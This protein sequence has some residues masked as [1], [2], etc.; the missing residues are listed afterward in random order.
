[1]AE[2]FPDQFWVSFYSAALHVRSKDFEANPDCSK[3]VVFAVEKPRKLAAHYDLFQTSNAGL[4]CVLSQIPNPE[5]TML[6]RAQYYLQLLKTLR[7][8]AHVVEKHSSEF[9][10]W[11]LELFHGINGDQASNFDHKLVCST[12]PVIIEFLEILS[13]LK[14]PAKLYRANDIFDLTLHLLTN[15]K[16]DIQKL[17][18]SA[19]ITWKQPGVLALEEQLR[20]MTE[21]RKF[22]SYLTR[23]N[24]SELKSTIPSTHIP[25]L[26]NALVRILYGKI[27]SPQGKRSA[28]G[29]VARRNA[30]FSFMVSLDELERLAVF[31][32]MVQPFVGISLDRD[33]QEQLSLLRKVSV[34]K[35]VGFLSVLEPMIKQLKNHMAP[36]L[37]K[38]LPVLLL[39]AKNGE[40]VAAAMHLSEENEIEEA[41]EGDEDG[42]E[43]GDEEGND[44]EQEADKELEDKVDDEQEEDELNEEEKVNGHKAWSIRP[45]YLRFIRKQSVR[46]LTEL[47]EGCQEFDYGPYIEP[48]FASFL[49][50]RLPKL[51]TENTQNPSSL[52]LLISSWTKHASF[53]QYLL[54][55][56]IL[57]PKVF[58]ILSAPVVKET[59][60]SQILEM[61]ESILEL[62]ESNESMELAS[63]VLGPSVRTFIN[64]VESYLGKKMA[65]KSLYSKSRGGS[66][67]DR[68]IRVLSSISKLVRQGSSETFEKLGGIL[69]P[70][71]R[72]SFKQVSEN[73]KSNILQILIDLVPSLAQL[74]KSPL[75]SPYFAVVCTMFNAARDITCRLKAVEFLELLSQIDSRLAGIIDLLRDL[76]AM[77]RSRV[78]EPDFDR[79]FNALSRIQAIG[80]TL[81]AQQ[82]LPLL[83]S[84]MH[85]LHDEGEYSIRTSSFHTLATFLDRASGFDKESKTFVHPAE[86]ALTQQVFAVVLPAI[87]QAMRHKSEL[88]RQEFINL[89]GIL[90]HRFP[91]HPEV[92]DLVFLLSDGDEEASFFNTIYHIQLHRRSRALRRLADACKLKKFSTS[93][94]TRIFLPLATHF[95]FES[96]RNVDTVL[97][98]DAI[99]AIAACA[100]LLQWGRYID[101]IRHFFKIIS[102]RQQN[103]K[104]LIR[105]IVAIVDKFNFPLAVGPEAVDGENSKEDKEEEE[106]DTET[107]APGDAMEV[108]DEAVP[109]V[110]DGDTTKGTA[111]A[112]EGRA[113]AERI[114]ST[115]VKYLLPTLFTHLTFIEDDTRSVR[116]PVAFGIARLLKKLPEVSMQLMLPKLLTTMCVNLRSRY[117]EVRDSI[118]QALLRIVI[119]LGPSYFL[120]VVKELESAL[121]RG[122][123]LHVLGY[124]IH[125]L[126]VGVADKFPPESLDECAAPMVRIFINDIFGDTGEERTVDALKNKMAE[127]RSTKSFNS[128]ELL[129]KSIRAEKA[130]VLLLPLKEIMLETSNSGT[131]HKLKEVLRHIS[132]G[133]ASNPKLDIQQILVFIH[134]LLSENL[135][136][137]QVKVSKKASEVDD[138]HRVK[139]SRKD[140][141]QDTLVYFSAN[142][143][144]FIE[145][146]LSL[147][148]TLI[149][150]GTVKPGVPA[151]LT[152]IDPLVTLLGKSLYSPHTSVFNAATRALVLLTTWP[153]PSLETGMPAIIFKLFEVITRH[154]SKTT[155]EVVQ[156][157]F[158]LVAGIIRDCS[159]AN[160][161]AQQLSTVIEM[162][163]PDLEEPGSHMTTFALI[164]AILSRK[165]I[166]K[167]V[168]DLMDIILRLTVTSQSSRMQ[169]L[170]RAAFMQF[171]T[172]YP[173]GPLKVQKHLTYIIKNLQSYVYE[174][175]RNSMI[176]FIELFVSKFSESNL[177][178]YSELLFCALV[179]SLVNDE[180]AKCREHSAKVIIRLLKRF[181]QEKLD[182]TFVLLTQWIVDRTNPSMPRAAIQVFG[183]FIEALGVSKTKEFIPPMLVNIEKA[184]AA[185]IAE[186]ERIEAA[187][188]VDLD[189]EERD[190][191]IPDVKNTRWEIGYYAMKT[192]AKLQA[193]SNLE[194][195]V[196]STQ[197][198]I[199]TSVKTLLRHPHLWIKQQAARMLGNLFATV[200]PTR[201]IQKAKSQPS[202]DTEPTAAS[203][204]LDSAESVFQLADAT[205]R[206][207]LCDVLNEDLA[208]QVV[209]NMVFLGRCMLVVRGNVKEDAEEGAIEAV[210]AAEHG[211]TSLH[212]SPRTLLLRVYRKMV[213]MA[214][215]DI[216]SPR[217]PLLRR[218]V[219]QWL[220]AMT[221]FIDKSELKPYL[222]LS[223]SVLHRTAEDVT[224]KGEGIDD[225]RNFAKEVM[226]VLS[227]YAGPEIYLEAYNE[228]SRGIQQVRDERRVKRKLLVV[229]NP[230]AAA[231]MK[232]RRAELK[233][234]SR[235]RKGDEIA[236]RKALFRTS[237]KSREFVREGQ[238]A[239]ELP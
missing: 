76:N 85:L 57:L 174:S 38:L 115:V 131:I 227:K 71:L 30:I 90:V 110:G 65:E 114:H 33:E 173:Q 43:D 108:D 61:V 2:K 139:L 8:L 222:L 87:R 59:V 104:E 92:S 74:S 219:F 7:P 66:L 155:V 130:S 105:V 214:R 205:R 198:R 23:L 157:A 79:R 68:T 39:I 12:Q 40:L 118:R 56:E 217:R 154:A 98:N 124:T 29:M 45:K 35:Q 37:P 125:M 162:L 238:K 36:L 213:Y 239:L 175:G 193:A 31:D 190:I 129:S 171:L 231:K 126:L 142:A 180:S 9:L 50:G 5:V 141:L 97:I 128:F 220:G 187:S 159:Y 96:D 167:E 111:A 202:A 13:R 44:E 95:V 41:E 18:L 122:Y 63:T 236:K 210:I 237:I 83:Y 4:D 78:G 46:R 195:T 103:E 146:G 166:S 123:Q 212:R 64:N 93:N 69:L 81:D 112:L 48:I 232:A 164:R 221:H 216:S 153:L 179:M 183:L 134:G 189:E 6:G 199:W 201:P 25:D 10:P 94:I 88:V 184:L 140:E 101:L 197:A 14:N 54:H 32:L 229:E 143:H 186:M 1:M 234:S 132:I 62:D 34:R 225:L 233:K 47:F 27:V 176:Y 203:V 28:T 82:W 72:K 169:E 22:R 121:K 16:Q 20:G 77:S 106:E 149:K 158:R 151:H 58:N 42:D 211:A 127:M 165:H 136:L 191:V 178:E 60:I 70:F 3:N 160:L 150:R 26:M 53:C 196:G 15:G 91:T 200:D 116:A 226:E 17:A 215:G 107:A 224:T 194:A 163:T 204:L 148:S 86:A 137:S 235:K 182:A 52:L 67:S 11:F 100:S 84:L 168:Y 24:V 117:F 192:F 147:L 144:L 138:R 109:E 228:I 181:E 156:S 75:Q 218:S 230:E 170:C 135:P 113:L 223:L 145:F 73:L 206:Q 208:K 21:D 133:L 99:E 102:R 177:A 51:D 120:Y 55:D 49:R 89:L 152:M 188:Q 185:T 119:E 19:L 207:L 209:K 161:S 172:E 80:A